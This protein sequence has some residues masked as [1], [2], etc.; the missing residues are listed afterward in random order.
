MKLEPLFSIVAAMVMIAVL[1]ISVLGQP[2]SEIMQPDQN[3]NN[4]TDNLDALMDCT[5]KAE[6]LSYMVRGVE[7]LEYDCLSKFPQGVQELLS[8]DPNASSTSRFRTSLM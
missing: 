1:P 3:T 8:P 6:A 2:Q 4:T 7:S 5:R